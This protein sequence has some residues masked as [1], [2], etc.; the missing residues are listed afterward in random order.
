MIDVDHFKRV[1]DG[2]GHANCDVVLRGLGALLG[3]GLRTT[4]FVGR[5]GGEEFTVL[6]PGDLPAQC[7]QVCESLRAKFAA[8][9]HEHEGRK[10]QCT[11]SLG[12]ACWQPARTGA[13]R[14]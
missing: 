13:Q 11:I 2:Y 6:L 14:P 5:Y 8:T 3:Q 10:L 1:N 4:D 12:I 9:V 7:L